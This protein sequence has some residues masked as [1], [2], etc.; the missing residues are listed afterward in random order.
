MIELSLTEQDVNQLADIQVTANLY[1]DL[2]VD[3]IKREKIESFALALG[4]VH[5]ALRRAAM[6]S[7]NVR[8]RVAYLKNRNGT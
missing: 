6:D 2:V 5:N 8:E 3:M 7:Q 4:A 1:A